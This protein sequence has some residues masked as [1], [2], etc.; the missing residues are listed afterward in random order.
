MRTRPAACAA[1]LLVLLTSCHVTDT[2][3]EPS[4]TIGAPGGGSTDGTATPTALPTDLR[5]C[6]PDEKNEDAPR[7]PQTLAGFT[8]DVPPGFTS[9]G[10]GSLGQIQTAEGD[11]L[12]DTYYML[13]GASGVE[14]LTLVYYR[15]LANGPVA[16][17]CGALDLDE[18]LARLADHDERS[19]STVT[20]APELVELAGAPVVVEERTYPDHGITVVH[21]WIYGRTDMLNIQCQWT[22]HEAEVRSGCE[23]LLASLRIG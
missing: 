7:V 8:I 2:G 21:Y 18:V 1:L 3:E 9:D 23:S 10:T 4:S 17:A 14:V 22:S 12:Q 6:P 19:G 13:E 16:D 20:V 15:T 5:E 11:D